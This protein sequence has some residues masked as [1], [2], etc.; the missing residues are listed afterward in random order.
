MS[1]IEST[2][3]APVLGYVGLGVMGGAMCRDVALKHPGD[4]WAFD[5]DARAFAALEH[6]K[7]QRAK[8]LA[9]LAA[10][11]DMVLLSLP[12]GRQVER[13]CLGEGGLTAGARKPA[14]IIDL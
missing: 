10:E 7:A 1:E 6:T 12:G 9:Q 11:A 5:L 2:V 8:D 3:R 4:V 13:V 14:I